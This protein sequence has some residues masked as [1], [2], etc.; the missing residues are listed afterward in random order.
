VPR[1][2]GFRYVELTQVLVVKQGD[3]WKIVCR[4][5]W[6]REKPVAIQH[7]DTK[8]YLSANARYAFNQVIQGQI[9]VAAQNKKGVE[10]VWIA[11]EGIYISS[12]TETKDGNSTD[13]RSDADL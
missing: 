1:R 10:E 6:L 3:D 13:Q 7:I 11:Q 9:E 12:E 5:K 2:V 8:Y 4:D